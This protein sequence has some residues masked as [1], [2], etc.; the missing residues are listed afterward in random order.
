MLELNLVFTVTD[1]TITTA[2]HNKNSLQLKEVKTFVK[3]SH[4]E[5]K[6]NLNV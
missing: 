5:F 4:N 1:R 3:T 2:S 6:H